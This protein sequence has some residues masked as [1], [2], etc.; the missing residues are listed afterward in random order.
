MP[1]LAL[2]AIAWPP[3]VSNAATGAQILSG[4]DVGMRQGSVVYLRDS[5][6]G[7]RVRAQRD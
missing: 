6:A 3:R 1:F 4:W 5:M 7:P 2:Y